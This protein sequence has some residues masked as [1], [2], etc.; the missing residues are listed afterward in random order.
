MKVF[1]QRPWL[2]LVYCPFLLAVFLP[3]LSFAY[4]ENFNTNNYMLFKANIANSRFINVTGTVKD[5]DGNPLPGVIIQVK[6]SSLSTVTNENGIYNLNLPVGNEVLVFNY[7]GFKKKEVSAAGQSNLNIILEEDISKLDEVVVIGYGTVKKRDL[8]GAVSSVKSEE[9]T[10]NPVSNVMESLQGRVAGLDIQRTDGR[11]GAEPT[12]LLR[13]RRSISANEAPLYVIDGI[14]GGSITSLNPNDI[15]SIEV[16]KDASSTAIYGSEG[17]NGVIIITTKKASGEKV[18]IDVNSYYGVNEVSKYPKAL[19]GDSWLQYQQDKYFNTHGSYAN[20][21]SDLNISTPAINAIE[22]QQ[23]LDWTESTFQTGIQQNHHISVRGG[24]AKTQGYLSLGY[25]GEEG[26]YKNDKLNTYNVRAGADNKFSDAFKVGIISTFNYRDQNRTNSRINKA[27]STYPLG[28][29]YTP[30]GSVN[31]KPIEGDDATISLIANYAPGVLVNN[32]K[33]FNL[34]INPYVEITP[35]KNLSIRSNFGAQFSNGRS[36]YFASERSYNLAIENKPKEASYETNLGY[37]YIWENIVNYNFTLNRNH[38]FTVTGV[39]SWQD[40]RRENSSI[41]G[42]GLDYDEFIYYNIGALQQITS[43]SSSFYGTKKLSFAGRLNYSY[44]GKY[45]LTLTNRWDGAS[46][47]VQKWASFPSV[48]AAWRISDEGFMSPTKDWLSNMKLRAG[49]GVAGTAN[50]NAYQTDT[51]VT[52]RNLNMTL[53]GS[54]ILPIYVLKAALGNKDITWERA[55]NT[56]IGLDMSFF[57]DRLEVVMDYYRTKTE[58]IL[59]VRRMPTTAGGVDAK[60]PY[61]KLSNIADSKNSGFELAINSRNVIKK[62]FKWNTALTF[63]KAKEKLLGIDLGDGITAEDLVSEGLF[64]GRP[65]G[66]FYGYKKIGVWQTDEATEAAKYG[67]KPGDIKLATNEKFDANGVSDNGIHPYSASDRMVLGKSNPDWTLGLQNNF[68][69]KNFDLGV[70]VTARYGQM[71]DADI[72]GYYNTL[73]QPAMYNYWT[74]TNPTNDYPSPELT[75]GI[76]STYQSALTFV[77]GSYFKIKNIT[78]GYTLPKQMLS[79]VGI[80]RARI[81]GTAYNPIIFSKSH[82]LRD[83]DPETGG[84][85]QFPLYKQFVFGINLSF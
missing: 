62:D 36:G 23:W 7:L 50:V 26:V 70:F 72:L 22:S 9:I 4:S 79:K 77:D 60:N 12:V 68:S 49:Y 16:L 10:A 76:S 85:D 52:S 54:N 59:Y 38:N 45:L 56:N 33:N 84:S 40:N 43:K 3:G 67:A 20:N 42:T 46:Q 80:G 57:K 39:S 55:Y 74:P 64:I 35:I 37:S 19:I 29:A 28:T 75:P 63:T 47:L 31:F 1:L 48:A 82:L 78:L 81:Y 5:K 2:K 11:S 8:T 27:F 24:T 83:I 44:K 21:L 41:V 25:I 14:P 65:I 51:E 61:T 71:I 30:D 13:G 15:E 58:G 66:T 18:Q 32:G 6:G 73:A 53:G 34:Q 69:Y 17:A